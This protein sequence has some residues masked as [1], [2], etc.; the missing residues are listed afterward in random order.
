M[1][2]LSAK[3]Q[4]C[5]ISGLLARIERHNEGKTWR[6]QI[7]APTVTTD[8]DTDEPFLIV[9][10]W[11]QVRR[12][13][14][15]AAVPALVARGADYPDL[16]E[17]VNYGFSDEYDTCSH[18]GRLIRTSPDSYSWQPDFIVTDGEILCSECIEADPESIIDELKNTQHP[19]PPDVN[20]AEHGWARV[21][22]R[23][24]E[25]GWFPGQNDD[26]RTIARTLDDLGIDYVFTIDEPS[27]FYTRWSVWVPEDRLEDV[28]PAIKG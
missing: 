19:L 27:Q 28:W 3:R 13:A 21:N 9:E 5:W 2:V 20:P 25:S 24:F 10:S 22:D 11:E 7:D 18:C 1:S 26:P 6:D 14:S 16:D 17:R 12:L 4:S 8:P 23:A 15:L